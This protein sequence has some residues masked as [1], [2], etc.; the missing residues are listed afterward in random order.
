[1]GLTEQQTRELDK[2]LPRFLDGV[3]L[4]RQLVEQ[5][6]EERKMLTEAAKAFLKQVRVDM[7]RTR[8]FLVEFQ[9][10]KKEYEKVTAEVLEAVET[11]KNLQELRE[12]NKRLAEALTG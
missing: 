12:I 3:S 8:E 6:I 2:V 9:Q 4:L 10:F 5:S 1:M 11:L 7:D